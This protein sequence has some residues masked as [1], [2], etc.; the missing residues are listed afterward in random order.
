MRRL[1]LILIL[2]AAAGCAAP[3]RPASVPP[4][5]V[6]AAGPT[7]DVVNAEVVIRVHPDGPLAGLG[8]SHLIRSDA[9]GGTIALGEPVGATSF[10]LELP[11]A[12]LVVDP[13]GSSA[14]VNDD[15]R[16]ATRHNMLGP[17]LL[18]A[19]RFPLLDIRA[20]GIEGGPQQFLARVQVGI[21]GEHRPIRV[22]VTVTVTGDLLTASGRFA[23]THR[24]LGLEPYSVA[25][26]ALRVA[27]TI[28]IEFRLAARR[29]SGA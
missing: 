14:A 15:Q 8:H 12:S 3:P 21:R 4:P 23:L 24:E 27:E 29:R 1:T 28:D 25:L 6:A 19:E 9:L 7:H 17:A 20:D 10:A 13:P 16:A 18:D 5:P 26:G 22:P 11:L 2:L